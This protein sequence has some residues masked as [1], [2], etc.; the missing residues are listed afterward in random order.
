MS[1]RRYSTHPP[2]GVCARCGKIK[3][4]EIHHCIPIS[5]GGKDDFNNLIPLCEDCHKKVHESNRSQLVKA[6]LKKAMTVPRDPLI[7]KYEVLTVIVEQMIDALENDDMKALKALYAAYDIVDSVK[8][9]RADSKLV[10]IEE[11][12]EKLF[13]AFQKYEELAEIVFGGVE[14]A[15]SD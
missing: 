5:I 11:R 7:S 8:H 12:Q 10:G 14:D 2:V 6:G 15:G 13:K 1:D 4:V 3:A 9:R